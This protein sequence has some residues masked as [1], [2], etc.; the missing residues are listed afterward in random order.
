M[1]NKV[2][3]KNDLVKEKR[4]LDE[5]IMNLNNF[6][7]STEFV[8]LQ[9]NAKYLLHQQSEHMTKYSLVLRDRIVD[10]TKQETE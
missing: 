5:K 10:I 8:H 3:I 7:R 4:K 1:K 6:I 2:S 9:N